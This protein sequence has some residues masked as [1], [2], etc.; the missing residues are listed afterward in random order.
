MSGIELS[1]LGD[2]SVSKLCSYS[3]GSSQSVSLVD[4]L[5][6]VLKSLFAKE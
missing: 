2:A 3:C 4:I 6:I 1:M 5:G